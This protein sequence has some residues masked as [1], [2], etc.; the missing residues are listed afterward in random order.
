MTVV[1]LVKPELRVAQLVS[2]IFMS[3][4]KVTNKEVTIAGSCQTW[5]GSMHRGSYQ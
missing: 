3:L 2:R 1:F 4:I 5:K